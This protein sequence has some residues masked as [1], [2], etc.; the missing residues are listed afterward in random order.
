MYCAQN[1]GSIDE[2][3]TCIPWI[4]GE[5]GSIRGGRFQESI[6][7]S[8]I[9][10]C[11]AVALQYCICGESSVVQQSRTRF[12]CKFLIELNFVCRAVEKNWRESKY[13]RIEKNRITIKGIF[14]KIEKY[15]YSIEKVAGRR[16]TMIELARLWQCD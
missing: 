11:I 16:N 6:W 4:T 8:F 7:N 2:K 9:S 10:Y 1:I 3:L 12:V 5:N 14:E 15:F 13:K